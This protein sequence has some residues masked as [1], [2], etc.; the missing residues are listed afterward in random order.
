[1]LFCILLVFAYIASAD[2][3]GLGPVDLYVIQ[4]NGQVVSAGF[5]S[6]GQLGLG[7]TSF[8]EGTPKFMIGITSA[9]EVCGS[10]YNGCVLQGGTV[11]CTGVGFGNTINTNQSVAFDTAQTNVSSVKCGKYAAYAIRPGQGVFGWGSNGNGQLGNLSSVVYVPTLVHPDG[12]A[13]DASLYVQHGCIVLSTGSV[14]CAGYNGQGQLG[15]GF[16]NNTN[17]NVFQQ[18]VGITSGATAVSVGLFH[19]CALHAGVPKCWGN[20]ES[21]QFGNSAPSSNVP[22]TTGTPGALQIICAHA[23]TCY[24][25]ANGG[26]QCSGEN[27]YGAFA[28]NG[29]S[30]VF[31][32]TAYGGGVTT[33]AEMHIQQAFS[34]VVDS[35][36]VRCAGINARG[37]FGVGAESY[38]SVSFLNT[39]FAIST[40]SPTLALTLAP[41]KLPTMP[42]TNAP[43][44]GDAPTFAPTL[45]PTK[46]P[47]AVPTPAPANA[48]TTAAPTTLTPTKLPTI[49]PTNTPTIQPTKEPTAAPIPTKIPTKLPTVA[50]SKLPTVMPTKTPTKSSASNLIAF[51][52]LL[53]LLLLVLF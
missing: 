11:L 25:A 8:I 40:F 7:F 17:I 5:N 53:L 3:I 35:G 22:V 44:P 1:M 43:A 39:G 37:Q 49:A 21:G 12:G 33:Y 23:A 51:P 24:Q 32:F 30:T 6:D 34:C 27:G 10:E 45:S 18:V 13:L 4:T 20:S 31:N 19:S 28:N 41:T 15:N 50:P 14:V 46:L 2:R 36:L 48:P 29:V 42:P 52:L 16:T 47:T 26:Y 9:T 38:D